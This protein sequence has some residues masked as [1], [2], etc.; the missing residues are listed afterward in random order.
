MAAGVVAAAAFAMYALTAAPTI[1]FGDGP[2]LVSAADAF[3]VAHPPGYPLY[4]ALGWLALRV[5]VGQPALR[6]NLLSSLFGALAAGATV[7]AG[8]RMTRSVAGGVVTGSVLAVSATLWSVS[9]VAEVYSLHLLFMVVL[10]AAAARF[11]DPDSSPRARRAAVWV[12]AAAAGCGAAH[13]PTVVLAAPAAACLALLPGPGEPAFAWRRRLRD[14]PARQ[15][16]AATVLAL[17]LPVVLY[18]TLLLRVRLAP[19]TSWGSISGVEE[20]WL[21]VRAVVYRHQDLGWGALAEAAPWRRLGATVVGEFFPGVLALAA[22]GFVGGIGRASVPGRVRVALAALLLPS[23]AF[24][25]RYD[26]PDVAVFCLPG[27]LAIAMACGAGASVLMVD[28]RRAVRVAGVVVGIA[29]VGSTFTANVASHDLSEMTAAELYARDILGTMP[30]GSILFVE[31]MDSFGPLY[32]MNVLG[33]RPDITTYDRLALLFRD[34]NDEVRIPSLPGESWRDHRMRTEQAFLGRELSRRDPPPIFFLGWPGYDIPPS[35]RLEPVG[36]LNR[37][38]RATDPPTDPDPVW[39]RYHDDEVERQ[40]LKSG[41]VFARATAATY[42][43]ARGEHALHE[44]DRAA[45]IEA[46]ARAGDLGG[47]FEGIHSYVGTVWGR[48]G[49]YP[50]AIAA[51]ERAVAIRP[52]EYRGWNNLAMAH[53]LAGHRE[54]ARAALARSLELAPY[55]ADVAARLRRLERE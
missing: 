44:G 17:A 55:Q 48:Y 33:E 22:L 25:L 35:F 15:I 36:L 16:V 12:A 13:H 21:H 46:F 34:L 32:L 26:V 8:S 4:T 11:G 28:S 18:S 53:E 7:W 43:V 37:L 14:V 41:D 52:S 2:E 31:S 49:D 29:A 1:P 54:E 47:E 9:T 30:P 42:E 45:A 38:R 10:C 27:F 20:L 24:G 23:I 3:G 40:A 19:H 51:L 5:P 6:M 50:R 39:A